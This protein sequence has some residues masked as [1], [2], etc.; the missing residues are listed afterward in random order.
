MKKKHILVLT[1][2]I[3]SFL[4]GFNLN[5][6]VEILADFLNARSSANF[7][8]TTKNVVAVLTK[9]TTGKVAEVKNFTDKNG[10]FTGNSG[11]KILITSGPKKG[12]S[13]WVY[14]NKDNRSLKL[15]DETSKKEVSPEAIKPRSKTKGTIIRDTKAIRD[16]EETVVRE[17]AQLVE[18]VVRDGVN[19]PK[20]E[21]NCPPEIPNPPKTETTTTQSKAYSPEAALAELN[22]GELKFVGRDLMPGSGQNRTC[23]YKNDKVYVLYGN[24]MSSKKESVMDMRIISANGESI[25]FYMEDFKGRP[26]SAMKREE[27]AGTWRVSYNKV[28]RPE[29]MNMSQIKNYVEKID[30]STTGCWVGGESSNNSTKADCFGELKNNLAD[31]APS[32][33]SFW[34]KPTNSWYAT[35]LK[36]RK[37]IQSTR[38]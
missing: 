23:I 25:H 37:V 24:C 15:V 22:S 2:F 10:K 14:N 4:V 21:T 32:A 13:Y 12:Q 20:I 16:P 8:K 28:D 29:Q 34:H 35:Q 17:T 9:G 31:W 6:D 30:S 1:L 7:L 3:S 26:T 38:F 36:M 11:V 18:N 5:D 33:E 19:P 27:Y